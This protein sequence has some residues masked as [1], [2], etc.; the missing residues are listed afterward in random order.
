MGISFFSWARELSVLSLERDVFLFAFIASY[1]WVA[2]NFP[3]H[4][5]LSRESFPSLAFGVLLLI[6]CSHLPQ[7][8]HEK[9]IV[10]LHQDFYLIENYW[11]FP[12]LLE[13]LVLFFLF[14]P[15]HSLL[16]ISRKPFADKPT[17]SQLCLFGALFIGAGLTQSEV[18]KNPGFL[19]L[20]TLGCGINY[21]LQFRGSG[22][23]RHFYNRILSEYWLLVFL[24]A[25]WV[26]QFD[27]GWWIVLIIL[28]VLADG[29]PG[30]FKANIKSHAGNREDRRSKGWFESLAF[31]CFF[32]L[33]SLSLFFW[34]WF[35]PFAL[36]SL[37]F[38]MFIPA[39]QKR[40][41]SLDLLWSL[42]LIAV[43]IIFGYQT[44]AQ[45]S[46]V[47]FF[48]LCARLLAIYL[49]N[50]NW[51]RSLLCVFTLYYSVMNLGQKHAYQEEYARLGPRLERWERQ[52]QVSF[53]GRLL[54]RDVDF[55]R[56]KE[57]LS[58]QH[59]M[60]FN[61]PSNE[62]REDLESFVWLDRRDEEVLG[63]S[64]SLY[65][66][67][68]ASEASKQ[69]LRLLWPRNSTVG[70]AFNFHSNFFE[71]DYAELLAAYL[72]K[73]DSILLVFTASNYSRKKWL[74]YVEPILDRF[75]TAK[76][77]FLGLRVRVIANASFSD[78]ESSGLSLAPSLYLRNFIKL[79][80]S[81]EYLDFR[82]IRQNL[83][84]D[85][86]LEFLA[87]DIGKSDLIKEWVPLLLR[88]FSAKAAEAIL[89]KLGDKDSLNFEYSL[90]L[91]A[92][93]G[94]LDSPGRQ[95]FNDWSNGLPNLRVLKGSFLEGVFFELLILN[96]RQSTPRSA[97]E[98]QREDLDP[99]VKLALLIK[100]GNL[101]AAHKWR[102]DMFL[103]PSN[104]S[105]RRIL[106]LLY[107]A[108]GDLTATRFFRP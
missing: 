94:G 12:W 38:L 91:E 36:F 48:A 105:E 50:S 25:F 56:N 99:Y 21:L 69:K 27:E 85:R 84:N 102:R 78:S 1:Q 7:W 16:L 57:D 35:T 107:E 51:K 40:G 49:R 88:N 37:L 86:T 34:E 3:Q 74:H 31:Y 106:E 9:V 15:W 41:T 28:V 95:L 90:A 44:L 14:I 43:L 32:A 104:S 70:F 68:F 23:P 5:K 10:W 55:H 73:L 89:R 71:K 92:L 29:V 4:K 63:F 66:Q 77:Q 101:S 93:A 96:V 8:I 67:D 60:L 83:I 64:P 26:R 33:A 53:A 47:F 2:L 39:T 18:L 24:A 87:T 13:F 97:M 80:E 103:K 98:V 82:K 61:F 20:L 54:Y 52:S 22:F 62:P 76:V 30:L 72:D 45:R 46:L 59:W 17:K 65:L 79:T 100:E 75:P 58:A 81:R 6:H 11:N 42:A 19:S 108:R